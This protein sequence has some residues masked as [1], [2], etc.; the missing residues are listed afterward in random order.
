MCS[1]C[2]SQEAA[3]H[4]LVL[5]SCAT[6]ATVVSSVDF[7]CL[8]QGTEEFWRPCVRFSA[9]LQLLLQFHQRSYEVWDSEQVEKGH[10]V[11]TLQ[12]LATDTYQ[13]S[14]ST[15]GCRLLRIKLQIA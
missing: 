4:I 11:V 9:L 12:L 10:S 1:L 15:Q 2:S 3:L 5:V 13:L 14:L 7:C 8:G 6:H